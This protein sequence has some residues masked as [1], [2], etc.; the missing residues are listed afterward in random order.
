MEPNTQ[1]IRRLLPHGSVTALAKKLGISTTAVS[2]ALKT[3]KPSHPAVQEATLIA[4]A[5]KALATAQALAAL[6]SA[7]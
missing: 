3:G 1:N 4:Q 5:S 2:K 7:K 6:A